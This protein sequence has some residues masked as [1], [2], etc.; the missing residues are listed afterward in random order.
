MFLEADRASFR[1]AEDLVVHLV[2][3]AI[4]RASGK[5]NTPRRG[6][7]RG[8]LVRVPLL[9]RLRDGTNWS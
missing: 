6:V 9:P 3:D 2:S 1:L 7:G 5:A 8:I 4:R